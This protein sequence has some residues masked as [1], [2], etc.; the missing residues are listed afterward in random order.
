M[1]FLSQLRITISGTEKPLIFILWRVS[2]MRKTWFFWKWFGGRPKTV[3]FWLF[4][5]ILL[6][7]CLLIACS[8][9]FGFNVNPSPTPSGELEVILNTGVLVIATDPA[10]PPHSEF[11]K[12]QSRSVNTRCNMTQYTANQFAGFDVEVAKEIARRLGVEPCFVTPTWSQIITGNWGDLWNVTVQSMVITPERMKNLY[13]TQ[14]YIYGEMFLFVHKDNQTI[15]QPA[16]LSGKKI[17]V[18]A[19]CADEYYLRGTLQIPGEKIET[20]IKDPII[21]GY[22]TD[23]SALTDLAFGDGKRLDAVITDPDTGN[24]AIQEGLPIKQLSGVLY[25]DFSAVAVDKMSSSD[26]VA[27][28]GQLTKIIQ[29]MHQD[30][31]LLKLSKQYYGG[32][33]T[34]L[35]S[36]FDVKALNQI[37]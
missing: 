34:T 25:R 5:N 10:A 31:T 9:T 28:V 24:V 16:D 21:F 32:D 1:V 20:L 23:T 3:R 22:D 30:Q 2:F 6:I 7:P 35:A 27:L 13:F 19:G 14:P 29:Q 36:Q 4:F 15:N 18:C 37:P 8:P 11:I 33:F 26:P 17:G 12:D